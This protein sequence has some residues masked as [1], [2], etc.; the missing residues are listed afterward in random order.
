MVECGTH[1]NDAMAFKIYS[2]E[3]QLF[4]NGKRV[5]LFNCVRNS[6]DCFSLA[7]SRWHLWIRV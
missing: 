1:M 2:S 3:V 4:V 5:V 7:V 6:R